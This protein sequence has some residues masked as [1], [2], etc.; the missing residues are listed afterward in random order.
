[1]VGHAINPGPQG[2]AGIVP[3]ETPPQLKMNVLAQVLALFRVSLVGARSLSSEEPYL[4]AASLYK[5]SWLAAPVVM[6]SASPT[7]KVVVR[8]RSF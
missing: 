1:M 4:S 8:N 5:S 2:T 7:I 3:L 6:D